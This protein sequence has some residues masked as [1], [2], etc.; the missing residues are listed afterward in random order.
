MHLHTLTQLPRGP[1]DDRSPGDGTIVA[2]CIPP[3]PAEAAA[4]AGWERRGLLSRLVRVEGRA[5]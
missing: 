3:T 4:E 1:R 2:T 5:A